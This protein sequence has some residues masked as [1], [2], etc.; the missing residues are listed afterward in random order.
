MLSPIP[1]RVVPKARLRGETHDRYLLEEV[2]FPELRSRDDIQNILFVGCEKYTAHY[3]AAFAD[4]SFVTID[5]D[6]FKA[7]YGA[8]RHVV[9]SITNL[10]A[11]FPPGAFDAVIFNGVIGWGLDQPDE[12]LPAVRNWSTVDQRQARQH[13][14]LGSISACGKQRSRAR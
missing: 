3:P 14:R 9:D 8:D 4:R 13:G 12:I 10:E 6:P 1:W 2:I 7:R 11:H 5:I